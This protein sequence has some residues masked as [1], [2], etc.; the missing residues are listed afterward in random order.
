MYKD[1][2][3]GKIAFLEHCNVLYG[4]QDISGHPITIQRI[5]LKP[6]R[7]GLFSHLFRPLRPLHFP[8]HFL[9]ISPKWVVHSRLIS[10]YAHDKTYNKL[11]HFPL[12]QMTSPPTAFVWCIVERLLHAIV[13]NFKPY[14]S[15]LGNNHTSPSL[16]MFWCVLTCK[17]RYVS[18]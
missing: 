2:Y 1:K 8:C 12:C 9:V 4:N 14:L 16:T 6:H 7:I 17:S 11:N 15:T 5:G 13:Y 10:T 3:R 18:L